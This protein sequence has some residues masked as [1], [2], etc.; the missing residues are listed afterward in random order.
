MHSIVFAEHYK[1]FAVFDGHF[2]SAAA[3]FTS[4]RLHALFEM[5]MSSQMGEGG[6]GGGDSNDC[7]GNEEDDEDDLLFADEVTDGEIKENTGPVTA[8]AATVTATTVT[9]EDTDNEVNTDTAGT[10]PSTKRRRTLRDELSAAAQ[11]DRLIRINNNGGD[12]NGDGK[13]GGVGGKGKSAGKSGGGGK[14]GGRSAGKSGGG[15]GG[16]GGKSGTGSAGSAGKSDVGLRKGGTNVVAAVAALSEVVIYG[17]ND[18]ASDGVTVYQAL[19][20][21]LKAFLQTNR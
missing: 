1:L 8:T 3:R 2:G 10:M 21:M 16:A 20:A 17:T 6:N 13:S 14:S 4:K 9:A 19:R 7:G 11:V 15:N 12:G 18:A 5:Y